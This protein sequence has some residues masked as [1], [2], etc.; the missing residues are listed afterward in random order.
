MRTEITKDSFKGQSF[1][2][3]IDCHKKSWN[4][5]ILGEHYEHKTFSQN[6]DPG[7]LASYLKRNFPGANYKAVYEAGFSGFSSCRNLNRLGVN[8]I[9][10]HP[11]D[12][13]TTQKEKEQK[14]I[15]LTVVNW[16]GLYGAMNLKPLTFQVPN[17]KPTGHWY[18]NG[19]AR[20][21][22]YPVPKTGSSHYFFNL[23]LTYL[24]SSL[25]HKPDTGQRLISTG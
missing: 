4:V 22:I 10:I 8:C 3:G 25:R 1:Y 11:A 12:V 20:S 23:G 6:P 16:P 17:W 18:V 13:P 5:T 24:N 14:Q 7:I 2:V 15:R 9:V 21:R 19:F